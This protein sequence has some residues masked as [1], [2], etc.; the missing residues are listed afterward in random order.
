[1]DAFSFQYPT[2]YLVPCALVAIA[3]AVWHYYRNE[4]FDQTVWLKPVLAVLRGLGVFIICLLLLEPAIKIIE[5]TINP[6]VFVIGMDQSESIGIHSDSLSEIQLIENVKELAKTLGSKYDVG[7]LSITDQVSDSL[8]SQNTGEK[9]NL[10]NFFEYV[11]NVYGHQNLA[12]VVLLS[13]GLYNE[14]SNPL[15]QDLGL[16]AMVHAVGLGDTTVSTDINIRNL[17]HNEIAFL[18]D[19]F[20]VEVDIDA[21]NLEGRTTNVK[22]Q[23]YDSRWKTVQEEALTFESND[24]FKTKVF[25]LEATSVGV[26]R[27]RIQISAANGEI[28]LQNNTR[29]F[30]IEVL[31][32]R[33][34]IVI[35]GNAPHPDITALKQMLTSV[36]NYSVESGMVKDAVRLLANADLVI[37]HDLPS[38]RNNIDDILSELNRRKIPSLFIPGKQVNAKA[39][40]KAQQIV[41]LN[42]ANGSVNEVVPIQDKSFSLFS[43][44]DETFNALIGYPPLL[45]PFGDWQSL[46]GS[47]ILSFQKIGNVSTS[48]PLM[49]FSEQGGFKNGVILGEGIWRWRM[50]NYLK[51]GSYQHVDALLGRMIQYLS[52]KENKDQ[53]RLRSNQNVYDEGD[54]ILFTAELYDEAY[55]TTVSPEVEL[56]I[57]SESGDAFNYIFSRQQ[58]N[59]LLD[60]GKLSPGNYRYEGQTVISGKPRKKV[61]QFAVKDVALEYYNTVADHGLLRT[62]SQK[63]GG[64]FVAEDEIASLGQTLLEGDHRPR[65]SYTTRTKPFI[66]LKWIFGLLILLFSVEWFLRRYYGRY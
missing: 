34:N 33:L 26:Q 39:F 65:I 5:D 50:I 4:E 19:R 58:S 63:Y 8:L 18:E 36:R 46:P 49:A 62:I 17:F 23:T 66:H 27:Y 25:N 22:L 38:S 31:D 40:N 56:V 59:Y 52:V 16:N 64:Q 42:D 51:E 48:Y 12:G 30:F 2:V 20:Q 53:F 60:A 28:S 9:T 15:Y 24:D 14:G 3:F 41:Q 10:S 35:L 43:Y 47:H 29:E 45:S 54:K 21:H 6:P 44:E 7:L 13:D 37:L 55:A 57:F 61:G 32:A 11:E 1:M